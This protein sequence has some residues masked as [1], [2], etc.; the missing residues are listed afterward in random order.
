M[1]KLRMQKLFQ[2]VSCYLGIYATYHMSIGLEGSEFSG[3][4]VT[5]PLLNMN[6]TAALLFAVAMILTIWWPRVAAAIALLSSLLYLPICVYFTMPGPF[7][8]VFRGEYSVYEPRN[9]VFCP[10]AVAGLLI[11]AATAV[12]YVRTFKLAARES[13]K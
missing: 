8:W 10:P 4:R 9:F 13:A 2:A 5:G 6:D 1:Q 12:V 3:G 7:R 11:A